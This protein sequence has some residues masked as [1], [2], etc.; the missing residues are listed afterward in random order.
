MTA[1]LSVGLIGVPLLLG[2]IGLLV[3]QR[4]RPGSVVTRWSPSKV[5]RY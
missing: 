5:P 2:L 4:N 3:P 1:A